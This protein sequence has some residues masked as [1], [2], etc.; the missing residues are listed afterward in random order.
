MFEIGLYKIGLVFGFYCL[1]KKEK[2]FRGQNDMLS[3]MVECWDLSDGDVNGEMLYSV[4]FGKSNE[5]FF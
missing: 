5:V 3:E 2:G 1:K 4:D